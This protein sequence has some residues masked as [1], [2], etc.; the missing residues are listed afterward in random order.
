MDY[1]KKFTLLLSILLFPLSSHAKSK[2]YYT[3]SGGAALGSYEAGFLFYLDSLLAINK[4]APKLSHL[5]G[6]S[7]GA[8]TS[9]LSIFT[10]CSFKENHLNPKKSFYWDGWTPLSI[11]KI[12]KKEKVKPDQLFTLKDGLDILPTLEKYWNQGFKKDCDMILGVAITRFNPQ[13]VKV[14]KHIEVPNMEE[15]AVIRIKGR[16]KIN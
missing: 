1:L 8:Y 15:V 3:I 10:K 4:K 13:G 7:A 16:G 2:I 11:N 5:T 9:L 14:N 12:F 6:A